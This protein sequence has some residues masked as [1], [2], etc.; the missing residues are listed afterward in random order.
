MSVCSWVSFHAPL[1]GFSMKTSDL[2]RDNGCRFSFVFPHWLWFGFFLHP[3]QKPGACGHLRRGFGVHTVSYLCLVKYP[4]CGITLSTWPSVRLDFQMSLSLARTNDTWPSV[5]L[6][7]NPGCHNWAAPGWLSERY[8][9]SSPM[10]LNYNCRQTP[11]SLPLICSTAHSHFS[12]STPM[13]VCGHGKGFL[14]FPSVKAIPCHPAD[15]LLSKAPFQPRLSQDCSSIKMLLWEN[16]VSLY[17]EG[18]MIEC[19]LNPVIPANSTLKCS[20]KKLT[21]K[22]HPSL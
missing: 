11:K 20:R 3:K 1:I 5:L 7:A 18:V 16:Y 2:V 9:H 22:N 6:P 4:L 8:D 10:L 15:S 12:S 17:V 14:P 13:W 21:A 19:C